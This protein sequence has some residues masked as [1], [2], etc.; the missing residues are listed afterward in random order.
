MSLVVRALAAAGLLG[1]LLA[2]ATPPRE[3]GET[4]SLAAGPPASPVSTVSTRAPAGTRTWH[5]AIHGRDSAAGTS[6]APLRRL[7]TAVDRAGSGDRVVVH[8]GAYHESVTVPPGKELRISTAGRAWLDGSRPV[9]GW[10]R[11]AVGFATPWDVRFDA[12]PTYTWGAAD[13]TEPGWSFVGPGHPMAA[14]PDQVWIDGVP[15]RQVGSLAELRRG[16]FF[17]DTVAGQL[18]VGS[19]PRRHRVRASDLARAMAIRGAGT[20]VDGLGVR[21]FAP[22]VPHMGAVTAEAPGISLSRMRIVDNATTGLHVSAAGARVGRVRL[23]RNGMLGMSATY[24]DGLRVVGTVARRNNTERFNTSPVAG[25][26]KIGRSRHVVVTG[27]R[28][29]ENAGTGL[30]FDESAYDVAVLNTTLRGNARHGL[31]LELST[32]ALVADSLVVGN[33]GHGVKVNNTAQVQL[34]NNTIV[35]NGRAINI[36][37]DDRDLG[38]PDTPGHDPR[39]PLPDPTMDWVVR[40]LAVHNNVLGTAGYGANCLLCVEDYS[41]RWTAEQLRIQVN[42]NVYARSRAARPTWVVVWSRAGRDPAVFTS[43]RE[44]RTATGRERRHLDLVGVPALTRT[45]RLTV[46][47]RR[48]RSAVAVPLARRPAGMLSRPVGSRHIGVWR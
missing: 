12:S 23:L 41:G 45:L 2:A 43:V 47:V 20:S 40:G 15:Q 26:A 8:A 34:W 3:A 9:A 14:H 31:S 24:A 18:H 4:A 27:S 48:Q 21:R 17:V 7:Q 29:S 33:R 39:R 44:F 5:V 13:G 19:D 6:G 25:G 30:W 38:D 35:R 1:G 36:V 16:T 10:R 37:Q 28:F 46:P 22:S 32:R 42:G 11:T